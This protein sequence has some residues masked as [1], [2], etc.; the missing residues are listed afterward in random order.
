MICG[1]RKSCRSLSMEV[2]GVG[3]EALDVDV[4]LSS[5]ERS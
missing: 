1:E 2:N 4:V 3:I 5:L